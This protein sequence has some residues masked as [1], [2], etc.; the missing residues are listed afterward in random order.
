MRLEPVPLP[1]APH[2]GRADPHRL[3]HRRRGP[4]GRLMR[5]LLV[6][7]GNDT[8]DGLGRQGRDARG[9]GFVAGE[10]STPSC[11]KRSCQRQ[12]MVLP[13]P[14]AR[15]MAVVPLPSAVRTMIRARQ[16]FCG[17][18]RSRMSDSKR[19]RSAGVTSTIIPWR[20]PHSRITGA[21]GKLK[22]GLFCQMLSTRRRLTSPVWSRRNLVRPAKSELRDNDGD[23]VRCRLANVWRS[24]RL[25]NSRL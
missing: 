17:L 4:M 20:M 15:V 13:L 18:L 8:I 2:R 19:A 14:T 10:P 1:D 22:L 9:P 16:T 11:M 21:S 12:T 25:I 7:Q 6:G 23:P 24:I 3:G 5:R